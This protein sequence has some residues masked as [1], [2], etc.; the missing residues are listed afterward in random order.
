M[1]FK[2]PIGTMHRLFHHVDRFRFR[3][4]VQFDRKTVDRYVKAIREAGIPIEA[5]YAEAPGRLEALF[6]PNL[7][8]RPSRDFLAPFVDEIRCLIAG[9]R[10]KK[11]QGMKPKTA[12][13]G[14]RDR[15]G[16]AGKTSYTSFKRFVRDRGLSVAA[17]MPVQRVESEPG[18]EVQIDYG[19]MGTWLR[20]ACRGGSGRLYAIISLTPDMFPVNLP[21][22][23]GSGDV[24]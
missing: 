3:L 12:W 6:L 7:K 17:I 24:S 19:K 5:T 1:I 9:D 13:I 2:A 10:D 14:V 15:H 18:G 21:P 22:W 23:P 8:A 16:L 11:I 20:I 4:E